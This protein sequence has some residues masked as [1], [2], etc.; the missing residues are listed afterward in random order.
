MLEFLSIL[1]AK[2]VLL[3]SGLLAFLLGAVGSV[4]AYVYVSSPGR[5]LKKLNA[6]RIYQK[7]LRAAMP[8]K[9]FKVKTR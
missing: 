4:L 7:A 6:N 1:S 5:D 2:P 3:A 8:I 9:K